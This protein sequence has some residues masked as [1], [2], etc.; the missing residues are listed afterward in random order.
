MLKTEILVENDFL[1]FERNSDIKHELIFNNLFEMS[2]ASL[3]HNRL[4]RNLAGI[5]YDL[6]KGNDKLECFHNDLRVIDSISNSYC[7]PDLLLVENIPL[8]VDDQFDT[9]TNPVFI[10]EVLS[11]STEKRD[12]I[13][14]F[15]IYKNIPSIKEYMIVA[16][17]KPYIKLF[18]KIA[19]NHWELFEFENLSDSVV[20]LDNKFQLPLL[21]IYNK[22]LK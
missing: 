5:I 16:Q 21:D 22:V 11:S 7:Y 10:A 17:H 19:V 8:F 18:K 2:G 15:E 9:L 4:V 20:I 6:L 13:E 12:Q 1:S 3:E 14:K